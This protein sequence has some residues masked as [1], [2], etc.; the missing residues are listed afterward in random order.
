M[1]LLDSLEECALVLPRAAGEA[2]PTRADLY[3]ELPSVYEAHYE[4]A[5]R[6]HTDGDVAAKRTARELLT[7]SKA[8]D[9][10]LRGEPLD[11]LMTM[12][13]RHK[14]LRAVLD[15]GGGGWGMARHLE[16]LPPEQSLVSLRD[17]TAAAK[18]EKEALKAMQLIETSGRSGR[19]LAARQSSQQRGRN[20]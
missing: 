9:Q 18:D 13:G 4:I 14:A 15:T 19:P 2:A 10:V 12:L 7:L 8:M 1:A 20:S 5:I 3:R 11:A 6:R 17:R 16:L